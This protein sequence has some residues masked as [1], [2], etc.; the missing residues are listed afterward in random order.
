L[1]IFRAPQG[2][3][4]QY[5]TV[6]HLLAMA[7]GLASVYRVSDGGET[8]AGP[9][10]QFSSYLRSALERMHLAYQPVIMQPGQLEKD[11]AVGY[12]S[13]RC[14][15]LPGPKPPKHKDSFA[16]IA[17]SYRHVLK[18][19]EG[20]LDRPL[21]DEHLTFYVKPT[22]DKT[23]MPTGVLS[24]A[25]LPMADFFPGQKTKQIDSIFLS[26]PFLLA[27]ARVVKPNRGAQRP[28]VP[29]FQ[30]RLNDKGSSRKMP[31]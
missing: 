25:D 6:K 5:A 8:D 2:E 31:P 21:S 20:T 1:H 16:D 17:S 18:E 14:P 9:F 26:S 19:I 4:F 13:L 12:Y 11:G 3:L 29:N 24:S 23:N 22:T 30:K 7:E 27:V 28:A 15:S 10:R